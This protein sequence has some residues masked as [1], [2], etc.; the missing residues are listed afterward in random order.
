MAKT[1]TEVELDKPRKM[2]FGYS[3]MKEIDKKSKTKTEMGELEALEYMIFMSLKED[4]PELKIE[5]IEEILN[6][7]DLVYAS[8]K[9]E[10]TIERD[11]PGLSKGEAKNA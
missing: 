1:W 8:E 10:E 7:V 3:V 9:L 6:N 11:M 2:R 5:Q 4:D